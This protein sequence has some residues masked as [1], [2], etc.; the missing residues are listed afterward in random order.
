MEKL[1]AALELI[2]SGDRSDETLEE[3]RRLSRSAEGVEAQRI[4][5]LIEAFHASRR[6]AIQ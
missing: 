1:K 4:G 5:D 6:N 3:L 2:K